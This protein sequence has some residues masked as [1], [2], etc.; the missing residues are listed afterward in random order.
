MG[1]GT[2]HLSQESKIWNIDGT[3]NKAGMISKFG[4][5]QVQTKGQTK[6]MRFPITDLGMEDLILGYPWLAKFE[7]NFCWGNAT[8]DIEYLSIIIQSLN[9]EKIHNQ[10][11]DPIP[12]SRISR[13]ETTPLTDHEKDQIMQEL[14][15]ECEITASIASQLAQDTQQYTKKVEIPEEY[16]QH[17]R[18]FSEEEAHQFLMSRP[19]DHVIKL[20]DGAPKAIDCKVYPTTLT[21]DEALQNLI[22][23]NW[24]RETFQNPNPHTHHPSSLSRKRMENYAWCRIIED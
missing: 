2:Q 5:L 15:Q 21:E 16:Q 24:Q 22:K 18:V 6:Q 4:N 9:Q 12:E 11:L 20:K 17:W 14:Q 1:L 3:A 19:W 13:I 23:N 7:P 10:L 8:I